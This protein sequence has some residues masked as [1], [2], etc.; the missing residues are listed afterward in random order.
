MVSFIDVPGHE[1]FVRNMLAGAHGIDAVLLVIAADESVMPQTREHF[2]ICRLLRIA[3]GLVVLTKCDLADG[4][5]QALAEVE[6][7]ELVSGSFLEGAPLLRVSA[8]TGEGLPALRDALASLAAE[9]P[10]RPAGRP[11]APPARTASEARA[12]AWR[13]GLR[14]SWP[15]RAPRCALQE[16]ARDQLAHL[17]LRQGLRSASAR[18][19]LVRAIRPRGM[20]SSRQMWKCS[21]V[22]GMTDSSAATTSTTAPMPCAPASMLRTK[23]SWPGTS[24]NESTGPPA[25]ARCAKPRSM[26]MPRSF[27][28]ASRSGSVPVSACTSALL[29]WSMCPA[30]PTTNDRGMHGSRTRAPGLRP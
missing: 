2:H 4:E 11:A 16:R 18:S 26:V 24:T 12:R 30:V 19:H 29:P 15:R 6:A 3:R 22:C 8:T 13:A 10:P 23:R 5:L 17:H 20:P 28:S 25:S 1:R 9:L 7:R 27:S 21:R 14:P